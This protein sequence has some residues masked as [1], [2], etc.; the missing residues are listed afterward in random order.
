MWVKVGVLVGLGVIV[1]VGG[2]S[3]R[4]SSTSS[5]DTRGESECSRAF[6][7]RSLPVVV[8]PKFIIVL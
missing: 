1:G 7:R 3:W 4:L 5:G 6:Q 2:G 8:K